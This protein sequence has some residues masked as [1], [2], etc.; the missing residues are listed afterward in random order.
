CRRW[1]SCARGVRCGWQRK[2]H[3]CRAGGSTGGVPA[4]SDRSL[5]VKRCPSEMRSTS[6]AMESIACSMCSR[7]CITS[8]GTVAPIEW[9]SMRLANALASGTPMATTPHM[10]KNAMGTTN[11]LTILL[12]IHWS[13]VWLPRRKHKTDFRSLAFATRRMHLTAM[14]QYGLPGDREP[15]PGAA[16]FVRDIRLPDARQAGCGD[17]RA[18][19]PYAHL[20]RVVSIQQQSA[21][22]HVHPPAIVT[23]FHRVD[24]HVRQRAGECVIMPGD[25]RH[26]LAHMNLD[27]Y[28]I[29]HDGAGRVTRQLRKVHLCRRSL[30]QTAELREVAR[31][32]LQSTRFGIQHFHDIREPGVGL[33][34]ESRNRQANGGERILQLVRHATRGFAERLEPSGLDL[35]CPRRG[36]FAGHLAHARTQDLE[37]G[38]PAP[39]RALRRLLA[40]G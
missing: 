9:R 11:G 19:V 3:G 1:V 37:L 26:I 36:Q 13:C 16:P 30:R 7:R 4:R 6:T 34:L 24:E 35:A 28:S 12:L 29:G 27:R 23:G 31:H 15:E 21:H 17:S 22:V 40:L 32:L 10:T 8:G 18:S 14:R 20:D 2:G 25:E 5:V 33:A 39:R 38:R